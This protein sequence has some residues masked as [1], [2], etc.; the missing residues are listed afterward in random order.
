MPDTIVT[1]APGDVS[2]EILREDRSATDNLRTYCR[3]V[4]QNHPNRYT[5]LLSKHGWFGNAQS[6]F[7][8][9]SRFR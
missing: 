6:G 3:V 8:T 4:E 5:S 9:A 7:S 2:L 1:L